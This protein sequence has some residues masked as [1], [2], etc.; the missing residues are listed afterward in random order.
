MKRAIAAFILAAVFILIVGNTWKR[1]A[2]VDQE[3]ASVQQSMEVDRRV[4]ADGKRELAEMNRKMESV[5]QYMN[6]YRTWSAANAIYG[7]TTTILNRMLAN[8]TSKHNL[9]INAWR[10]V[11]ADSKAIAIAEFDIEVQGA[12]SDILRWIGEV[13]AEYAGLRIA[14]FKMEPTSG[15]AA[16]VNLVMQV[17]K[18]NHK[19][20]AF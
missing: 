19:I 4:I 17:N 18:D 10:E 16:K 13:E 5:D 8:G 14:E 2:A 7:N 11:N 3:I 1:K 6:Y 20:N 9:I 12:M 15:G